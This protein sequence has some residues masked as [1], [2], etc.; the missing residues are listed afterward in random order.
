MQYVLYLSEENQ[1]FPPLIQWR[2]VR[3]DS[4]DKTLRQRAADLDSIGA[5]VHCSPAG[6]V[7]QCAESVKQSLTPIIWFDVDIRRFLRE[8]IA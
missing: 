3:L 7:I 4:A 1:R 5:R 2:L 8:E 6:T